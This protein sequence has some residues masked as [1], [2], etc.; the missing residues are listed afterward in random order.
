MYPFLVFP[1]LSFIS[2]TLKMVSDLFFLLG[3]YV[4]TNIS[5]SYYSCGIYCK[6]INNSLDIVF[7]SNK[8]ICI[9]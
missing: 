8:F 6:N 3:F 4:F 5:R 9:C 7:G 2:S 1:L